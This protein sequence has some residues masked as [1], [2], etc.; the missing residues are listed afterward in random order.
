MFSVVGDGDSITHKRLLESNPYQYNRTVVKVDCKNHLLR[1][2]QKSVRDLYLDAKRPCSPLL[3]KEFPLMRRQIALRYVK[4]S[5][6]ISKASKYR[7]N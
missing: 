2:F 1:D 6:G 3:K 7:H 5:A 4:L